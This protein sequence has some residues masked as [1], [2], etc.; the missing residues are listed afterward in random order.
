MGGGTR[1]YLGLAV[2]GFPNLFTITGPGSPSVL[3]NMVVSIEHHVN[4][5]ADCLQY[6]GRHG[7]RRIEADRD[8]QDAWVEH[9]NTI[10]DFTVFPTCNSWY[11]GANVPGKPRVFMPL[12]GFPPTCSGATR[13]RPGATRGSRSA[14]GP[15]PETRRA[16][17]RWPHD[18]PD[19]GYNITISMNPIVMRPSINQRVA[20]TS[21]SV[22]RPSGRV[23]PDGPTAEVVLPMGSGPAVGSGS[24]IAVC[25]A[26]VS[27]VV[28]ESLRWPAGSPSA[29]AALGG[30]VPAFC[31]AWG[32]D[33]GP[34]AAPRRG[35][36]RAGG[37]RSAWAQA[38][39]SPACD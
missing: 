26:E 13:W 9:V 28:Y 8:A 37:H 1:A 3:T 6:L 16:P 21:C 10:A 29:P 33:A 32:I 23:H 22:R 30:S 4:W 39:A 31:G 20:N 11:L 34:G 35:P 19:A 38:L 5:V 24:G 7:H 15:A 25:S 17:G 27:M 12:V 18:L 36:G 14:G 2:S